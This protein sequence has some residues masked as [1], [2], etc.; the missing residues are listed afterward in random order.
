MSALALLL[1]F[2]CLFSIVAAVCHMIWVI[3][4]AIFGQPKPAIRHSFSSCP[5]C[6]WRVPHDAAFCRECRL[7]LNGTLAD[8]LH[9]IRQA[10]REI[11]RLAEEEELDSETADRVSESLERRLESLFA[12]KPE[13]RPRATPVAE[14]PRPSAASLEL[15]S[16]E[17]PAD[18][19]E[20]EPVGEAEP[21]ESDEAPARRGGLLVSFLE[22]NNILWGELV[23]GLL[24][25][26]CSIALVLTLWRDLRDLPYSSF[27]LAAGITA[28][29][30][31]AGQY[32]LHHWRLATTSRGLLVIALLLAPLNLLLLADPGSDSSSDALDIAIRITAVLAFVGMARTAGRDLI[33]T[34]QLP[35]PI[36][37]RWLLALAV[38]G[39]PAT[40]IVPAGSDPS[41]ARWLPLACFLAAETAL[42]VGVK[43]RKS[44]AEAAPSVLMFVGIS[45]YALLAS[46][47]WLITRSADRL[48]ALQDFALPLAVAGLPLVEA[49]LFAHRRGGLSIAWRVAG[50]GTALF[51]TMFLG[52]GITLAWPVPLEVMLVALLTGVAFARVAWIERLPWFQ[53]GSL[54]AFAYAAILGVHGLAGHW[55]VP[56]GDSPGGWLQSLL[57]DV[58]TGI[59]LTGFAALLA[60]GSEA[61]ARLGNRPQAVAHAFGALIAASVGTILV[62][63]RGEGDAWP[64]AIVHFA[65]ALGLLAM[66]ARWRVRALAEGGVLLLIAGT[67]WILEAAAHDGR[68]WWG[69][70][71]SLESFALAFG[72]L[73]MTRLAAKP[74]T[75]AVLL[76]QYRLAMANGAVAAGIAT[77]VLTI[78]P[79]LDHSGGVHS[80]SILLLV[81]AFLLLTRVFAA[82]WPTILAP[83]ILFLGLLHL[84]VLAFELRP[85]LGVILLS[86]LVQ[87]T[88]TFAG[89]LAFK[90]RSLVRLFGGPL[91]DWARFTTVV[92]V[93]FLLFPGDG[94]KLE[95]AGAALWLAAIW[96]GMAWMKREALAFAGMQ[97]AL[98]I[99][100]ILLALT[101]VDAQPWG[102]A[103]DPR[104]LQAVGFALALLAFV[105]VVARKLA[106]RSERLTSL[107][108]HHQ[109]S[110]DRI[111][112]GALA[113]AALL[114]P[115]FAILPFV[116]V[117]LTPQGSLPPVAPPDWLPI[118]FATGTWLVLG[119]L[120]AAF[121]AAVRLTPA[122]DRAGDGLV[123]GLVLI[124]FGAA[125]AAAGT[126]HSEIAAASALRWA[127]ALTFLA[128]TALLSL[129]ERIAVLARS[130]GVMLR[131][132][133]LLLR[134]LS[135]ALGLAAFVAVALTINVAEIGL[136]GLVPSGP[137]EGSI[138]H[139]LGWSWSLIAPLG[140]IVAGLTLAAVREK[141][142]GY[143][144]VAGTVFA[145]TVAGGYALLVVVAGGRLDDVVKLRTAMLVAGSISFWALAWLAS[146]RWVPGELP[147]AVQT[148]LGPVAL[149]LIAIVPF[150]R[151]VAHPTDALPFYYGEFA[152]YGWLLLGMATGAAWW[153]SARVLP[154]AREHA[155]GFAGLLAGILSACTTQVIRDSGAGIPFH[156]MTAVWAAFGLAY[157][158]CWARVRNLSGF[159]APVFA[160]ALAGA[161]LVG[162]IPEAGRWL[163]PIAGSAYILVSA[164]IVWRFHSG[165]SD[166]ESRW[167]AVLTANGLLSLPV[168][169]YALV[170]A[171]GEPR[172]FERMAGGCSLLIL[173]AASA[174]FVLRAPQS[175]RA[176]VQT[177]AMLL[178]AAGF[179][180][181]GWAVPNP[182]SNAVWLLRNGW[183][184]VALAASTS[185]ALTLESSRSDTVRRVGAGLAGVAIAL[186]LLVLL[187]QVP[188][189]DPVSRKT[190][191]GLGEVLAILAGIAALI[192]LAIRAAL[193][194]KA[195]P[196]A[197]PS[198]RRT[199]Y[200]Y[201][202][203]AL[204][205]LFF[206]QVRLNLP[207]VFPP[208]AG[209][210]W[211]FLVMLFA[212]IG[213]GSAELC[214]RR[215]LW[216]L[217]RPLRQT[218]VL[219]PLIPLLAFWAKP[220]V[221]LIAWADGT[222]PGARP[223]LGYL[224][225]LPQY[226]DNYA[227]LWFLAG[228]LYGLLALSRRSFGWALL[229][230]LA[231]NAGLWAIL[232]HNEV[233]AMIHPQVWVIPLAL[234]VLIS[235]HVHRGS[236]SA[237]TSSGLRYLGIGM[238]LLSSSADMFIAGVGQSLWLPVVLAVF[239]VAGIL[240]GILMRVQAFL[241][242]GVGFLLLDVFAMI[243]HAAVDRS[244][245]WVWYAS[246]IVLGVAILA[247]FALFEKR[248]N[249]VLGMMDRIRGWD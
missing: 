15:P 126:F 100:A 66:N 172:T 115:A 119:T 132:S 1:G 105:G 242:L 74:G 213:V 78:A 116:E 72:A 33:H 190:P 96:F 142:A 122:D 141:S 201:L 179:V 127:L 16:F 226:F 236:L 222:A 183:A 224:E 114:L 76:R 192:V 113:V 36:D 17:S 73:A 13:P 77:A 45:L 171:L 180:L 209:R 248:R 214:E 103:R 203:E 155:I 200:V 71:T 26:G 18:L 53:A 161:S 207:E 185:I 191:L 133:P 215:K 37:R 175:G 5:H 27:L 229:A 83:G 28:A 69:M 55:T 231:T 239:C 108:L 79:L 147:L 165:E 194:P 219:L 57:G 49:G 152:G 174:V 67:L 25:V 102:E 4:R 124:A 94:M 61:I 2:V 204:L 227:M 232:A 125:V 139:A 138:F 104:V 107:W 7:D 234:I 202:A 240:A 118:A 220:P 196:L 60:L 230:A 167:A 198:S 89:S 31:G 6:R 56:E 187:Q 156:A 162:P 70:V 145:G 54:P 221:A 19:P 90:R 170:V 3:G 58:L 134:V 47:G 137:A 128:G 62:S 182:D 164:A 158:F 88:A 109:L 12:G 92:V 80:A 130:C 44:P 159:W 206:V 86:L 131:T 21:V 169:G 146:K 241:F 48:A 82:R 249:D 199:V 59:S 247:L 111:V 24:I 244:Q 8:Q 216:V 228:F 178:T 121:L 9:R 99:A 84:F 154:A 166:T 101:W 188:V 85:V 235:E 117:E 151:L 91:H 34:D 245:T 95:W 81:P 243:W 14:P 64:A 52:A 140:M 93:P 135:V 149:A 50:T 65:F 197:L 153:Q 123:F 112:L 136:R 211:T 10:Q 181:V 51:G 87:S 223:F 208:E 210:Y 176:V 205:V 120:T 233:D 193:N 173:A 189:F 40:Q 186:L 39:A 29:L 129:R 23:G 218:G 246:G 148:I 98:C 75:T 237:R 160:A 212:F 168:L 106:E 177:A 143:A 68:S 32:T 217:A 46:W 20:P 43:R 163:I 30:F 38:V 184:F 97:S 195:D 41:L 63:V 225:K 110:V 22:E 11:R 150:A 42:L 35:G 144:F 157:T 238:I